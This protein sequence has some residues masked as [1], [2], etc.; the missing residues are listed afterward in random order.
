METIKLHRKVIEENIVLLGITFDALKADAESFHLVPTDELE[1]LVIEYRRM[2]ADKQAFI[3][4][5]IKLDEMIDF[6]KSPMKAMQKITQLMTHPEKFEKDLGPIIEI[7]RK[8][9][10]ITN[11]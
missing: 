8:D 11:G 5:S 6:K 3:K 2:V 10:Q 4:A 1:S 7:F 9:K